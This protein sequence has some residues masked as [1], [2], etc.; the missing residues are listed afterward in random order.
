MWKKSKLNPLGNDGTMKTTGGPLGC[1]AAWK[2]ASGNW[3]TTIQSNKLDPSG[4]TGLKTSFFTSH[5]YINWSFAGDLECPVC[6][7]LVTP[8]SDF[9]PAT[10]TD[11]DCTN[12]NTPGA[13]WIFGINTANPRAGGMIKGTFDRSTLKLT[14]DKP[15]W[16]EAVLSGDRAAASHYAYDYGTGVFPKTYAASD[17]RRISWRWIGGAGAPVP[18]SNAT[19]PWTGM[20][21]IPNLITAA[22]PDDVTAGMLANPVPELEALRASPPLASLT[23][24]PVGQAGGVVLSKVISRHYDLVVTFA[25]LAAL[26]AAQKQAL[27]LE[28][29]VFHP[30]K[31]APGPWSK[32]FTVRWSGMGTNPDGERSKDANHPAAQP[33]PHCLSRQRGCFGNN[34]DIESKDLFDMPLPASTTD[35]QGIAAC[36]AACAKRPE[37]CGAWVFVSSRGNMTGPRCALKGLDYCPPI[38]HANTISD[39]MPNVDTNKSCAP[40]PHPPSPP[41]PPS[42]PLPPGWVEGSVNGGPLALRA[43]QDTLQFRVLVDGSVVESFWDGGR[44]RTTSRT[45]NPFPP[46]RATQELGLRVSATVSGS[47]SNAITAD[48]DAWEMSNMWVEPTELEEHLQLL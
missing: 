3:T 38:A 26:T 24:Q 28:V 45:S 46:P 13:K 39:S 48:I 1:T 25:G 41:A 43:T 37:D 16:A 47:A 6:D 2:E 36:T 8:C 40:H 7:K 14:P 11:P 34:T 12:P 18:G 15:D 33:A 31:T 22:A 4:T 44:A 23:A 27:S 35:E 29:D 42:P 10:C 32:P 21:T 30:L 20:Q 5:N 17:G 19:F 9:Y